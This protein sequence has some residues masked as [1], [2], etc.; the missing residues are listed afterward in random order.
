MLKLKLLVLPLLAACLISISATIAIY[1]GIIT[2]LFP[3]N[4]HLF[5][6][7]GTGFLFSVLSIYYFFKGRFGL[8]INYWTETKPKSIIYGICVFWVFCATAGWHGYQKKARLPLIYL[9]DISEV[10]S[11][12][13]PQYLVLNQYYFKKE[14][15]GISR[16]LHIINSK[17]GTR[18]GDKMEVTFT[19]PIH[20]NSTD[21]I[22]ASKIWL[23]MPFLESYNRPLSEIEGDTLMTRFVENAIDSFHRE[24]AVGIHFFEYVPYESA[25]D[26]LKAATFKSQEGAKN[27][28]LGFLVIH[29]TSLESYINR[30]LK[31]LLVLMCFPLFIL[32]FSILGIGINEQALEHE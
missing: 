22:Q 3:E 4:F 31:S 24:E 17:N 11:F 7:I 5:L 23:N 15:I 19:C 10:T 14:A 9:N 27:P 12:E 30:D 8:F 18:T 28:P 2:G 13:K 1:E 6:W 21:T 26:A 25:S 16:P 32:L 20:K 29:K